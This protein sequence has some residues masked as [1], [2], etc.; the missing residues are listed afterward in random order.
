MGQ[1][2]TFNSL[3]S[4]YSSFQSPPN[5]RNTNFHK[6]VHLNAS[7]TGRLNIAIARKKSCRR[8][9]Q[10]A[11]GYQGGGSVQGP[12]ATGVQRKE[13]EAGVRERV[14]RTGPRGQGTG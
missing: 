4:F 8:A 11:K 2:S 9:L 5:S 6:H 12:G 7:P 10:M 13:T 3:F 1:I 14:A